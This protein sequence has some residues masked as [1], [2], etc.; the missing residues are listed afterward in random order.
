MIDYSI[1]WEST[2]SFEIKLQNL[3]KS[4]KNEGTSAEQCSHT[5][6]L[7]Q[8]WPLM[9]LTPDLSET[10]LIPPLWEVGKQSGRMVL[11][12]KETIQPEGVSRSPWV[13][14]L[15][16][17]GSCLDLGSCESRLL[18]V[19]VCHVAITLDCVLAEIIEDTSQVL[20]QH[21]WLSESHPVP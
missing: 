14:C 8:S 4:K 7:P 12:Q 17:S 11:S 16:F 15:F 18:Y 9:T 10:G 3:R 20:W 13:L 6:H 2:W 5:I 1:F 19:S 21:Q